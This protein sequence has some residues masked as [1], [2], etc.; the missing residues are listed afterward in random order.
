MS[1]SGSNERPVIRGIEASGTFP[2]EY[3]FSHAKNGNRHLVVV[4]ANFSAPDEYG[5]SNGVFDNLR[6]NIL[7]IRDLFDGKNSYYMCKGMDFSLERSVITLISNVMNSLSITPDHCTMFGGSKGGSAA[8]YFGLKYG[9][10]SIVSIVPQFRVG[11][12]VKKSVPTVAEFMMGE[13][14]PDENLRFLDSLIP[15]LV[16]EGGNRG[17]N[18]YMFSAAQDEQFKDQIEPF[19]GFFNGYDN[20][21]FIFSDSPFIGDHTEV[22]RRNVPVIMG[23]VNLLIDGMP[24]RLGFVRNGF[25][26]PD[27][28]KS[29]IDAYL[30]STSVVQSGLV[31]TPTVAV[32]VPHEQVR[33]DVV[34]FA[35]LAPG[36]VRV[37][38]WENGKFLG[39]PTV[40]ADG[41]W[42]WELG[43]PWTKG[44]H[45]I[46]LFS[47]DPSGFHSERTEVAFTIL[48]RLPAPLVSMPTDRQQV[49]S[50]AVRFTGAARDATQ[51]GFRED[52]IPL[53]VAPV[54]PDGSWS[55][56]SGWS[57]SAGQHVVEVFGVDAG[58]S[59]S[60]ASLVSFTAQNMVTAPADPYYGQ[61]Y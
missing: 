31:A 11:S 60:L 18:I 42:S 39:S 53:G 34:R 30:K 17:A 55:W 3:R 20:F 9:F 37:S 36:A 40:A 24:P 33:G 6:S 27:R 61:R 14:V 15:D 35:G 10:G 5:W 22:T 45:L 58:G 59:E 57:W 41:T 21:N 23:L 54:A 2:V 7:W 19:L 52:G 8:L 16:R 47:V 49:A 13:G 29:A 51:V 4:F 44:N 43:R 38:L 50:A 25:E 56:E 26:E 12:Y 28:D 1:K 46:R 32:P 48:D